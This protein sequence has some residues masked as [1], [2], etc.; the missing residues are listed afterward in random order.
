M[1]FFPTVFPYTPRIV[2]QIIYLYFSLTYVI[3]MNRNLSDRE[4]VQ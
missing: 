2:Y 3:L 1:F 4:V